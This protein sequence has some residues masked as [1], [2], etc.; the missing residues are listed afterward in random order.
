METIRR[1]TKKISCMDKS[2][3]EEALA[4]ANE[5]RTMSMSI[6]PRKHRWTGHVLWHD[7]LLC[8]LLEGRMVG[9]PIR[10]RRRLEMLEDLYQNNSYEVL[11][12]TAEDRSAW[13][14]SMRKKVSKTCCA[15]DS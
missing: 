13:R 1:R 15:A 7:E 4:H 11:K 10:G 8:N 6:W 9:K 2:R 3:N 5:M 12:R 14:E